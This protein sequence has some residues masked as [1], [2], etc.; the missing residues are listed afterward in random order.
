MPHFIGRGQLN[1]FLCW[2][3]YSNCLSIEC[4]QMAA[5]LCYNIRKALLEDVVEP[6]MLDMNATF[7]L[8]LAAKIIRQLES[9]SFSDGNL[10]N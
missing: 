9:K 3:D 2:L 7:M 4:T 8:V 1:E 5:D 10:S 6:S